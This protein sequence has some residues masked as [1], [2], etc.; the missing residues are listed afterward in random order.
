MPLVPTEIANL[1]LSHLGAAP[2]ADLDSDTS[3]PGK[4]I[5]R[6]YAPAL[7]ALLRSFPQFHFNRNIRTLTLVS[8]DPTT[9]WKYAYR[10]DYDAL[11]VRR[12]LSGV[13]EDNP[14]TVI[15]FKLHQDAAGGLIYTNQKDAVAELVFS[16]DDLADAHDD[17]ALALSFELAMLTAPKIVR[18]DPFGFAERLR[19]QRDYYLERAKTSAANEERPRPRPEGGYRRARRGGSGAGSGDPWSAHPTP[20]GP[21]V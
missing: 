16:P 14:D 5:R 7:K 9:E 4:A 21:V 1:T 19:P 18:E 12:I 3:P 2:I 11:E 15:P 10:Y 13:S 6:F 17:F 8:T 20:L